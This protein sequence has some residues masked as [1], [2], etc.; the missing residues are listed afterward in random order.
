MKIHVR[1]PQSTPR[2]PAFDAALGIQGMPGG[3]CR[4]ESRLFFVVF[5]RS[6]E[7]ITDHG[8][9]HHVVRAVY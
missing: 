4:I 6:N 7:P 1:Q 9:A 5:A 8:M 2:S 3:I